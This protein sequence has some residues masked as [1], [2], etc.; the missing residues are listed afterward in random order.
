MA[1]ET[2][3]ATVNAR[4]PR[5]L[6]ERIVKEARQRRRSGVWVSVADIIREALNEHFM[7]PAPAED[8]NGQH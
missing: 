6:Y 2:L 7:Q 1:Q 5:S 4:V 8:C 3:S